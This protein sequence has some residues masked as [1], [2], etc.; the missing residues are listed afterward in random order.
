MG[1]LDKFKLD[2]RT[3]LVT[4][5]AGPLFGSSITQALAE[6]GATV[7]TASRSLDRN[8][9]HYR[10]YGISEIKEKFRRAGLVPE[11][12]R[13]MNMPGAVGW[14]FTSRVL[15]NGILPEGSLGLFNRLTPLFVAVERVLPVPFGLSIIAVGRKPVSGARE[16]NVLLG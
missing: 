15:K 6:A 3:A 11:K 16:E 1:I 7:I 12:T 4:A 2:G 9:D 14:F 13:R 5:G 10:R 8:L